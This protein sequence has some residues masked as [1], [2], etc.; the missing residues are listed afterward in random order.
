[1]RINGGVL[2]SIAFSMVA[3]SGALADDGKIGLAVFGFEL[4]DSSLQGDLEGQHE[5]DLAR[6]AM[7]EADL[8][9]M[10]VE[11]GRYEMVE[12]ESVTD[13]VEAAGYLHSCNGCE[14]KIAVELGADQALIGWVQKV[15]NLILNLNVGMR[16][17][18]SQRKVFAAS[19][20]IRGN[21]DESWRHGIRYLIKRKLFKDNSK[22]DRSQ[23]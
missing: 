3:A 19:V 8:K 16:D 13:A 9:R 10:L 4:I 17:V 12:V 2:A 20:D 7:I 5:D 6:L 18:E 15:S 11:S 21:T 14:A 23:W 22:I 1:M